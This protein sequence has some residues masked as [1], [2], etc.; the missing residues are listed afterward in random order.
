MDWKLE[1]AELAAILEEFRSNS[2]ELL[3]VLSTQL[4]RLERNPDDHIPIREMFLCA[5]TIKGG[6]AMLGLAPIRDVMHAMEDVLV[7]LR[8]EV[9]SLDQ[10]LADLLFHG[11][12][13][14]A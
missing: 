1:P 12:D 8:D 14:D 5:H 10:R 6:A 3:R 2:L 9:R 7:A 4:L 11:F 13:L